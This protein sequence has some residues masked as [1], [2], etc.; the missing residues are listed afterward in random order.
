MKK[1]QLLLLA[2]LLVPALVVAQSFQKETAAIPVSRAGRHLQIPWNGG[3]HSLSVSMPDIDADGDADLLLCGRDE[4]RLQFYRND[5]N[6]AAGE[7]TLAKATLNDL[8]LGRG[9]NR[10]AFHDLDADGDIDLLVGENAG[11]LSFYRNDGTASNPAFSLVTSLFDS[12]DVGFVSAPAFG[13]LD[14]DGGADLLVGSYR[15]GIFYYHRNSSGTHAFT[16]VDTLRDSGGNI[17]KPGFQFYVPA[18]ADIDADGDLDLFASSS[19][20]ALAFYRNTGSA[21]VP[22]FTLENLNFISPP[23][24][25]SFLTPAFVDIDGDLDLDLF[26]GSNH[27][28]VTFYRNDGTPS[29]PSFNLTYQQLNLDFL[30]FGFHAPPVLVDIDGDGDLDLFSGSESGGLH[31]LRN[32]GDQTHPQF[33]WM[34]NRFEAILAGRYTA[35]TWG[36]LDADG[37]FDLLIGPDSQSIYLFTNNGTATSA[38][39]DSIG[40]LHDTT[41]SLVQGFRPELADLDADNDLDLLVLVQTPDQRNAIRLYE[42]I[43]TSQAAIFAM[44][45]DSLRDKDGKLLADYDMFLRLADIDNDGDL[46]LFLGTADGTIVFYQ[47]LGT[48]ANPSFMLVTSFFAGVET[49][50]NARCL[51]FFADIDADNDLDVFVGRFM[52]GLFFYRNITEPSAV[53]DKSEMVAKSFTLEQNYPNPFNPATTI[54]FALPTRSSVTLKLFDML[55]REV[56]TLVDKELQPG[57]HKVVFD[58]RKLP[59]GVYFYLLQAEE[60][61]QTKK[62][63]LLK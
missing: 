45:P 34:T 55:G 52:G 42:N 26:F 27:G 53:N 3:V 29:L 6:G 47:N 61:S 11:Q 22:Q 21:S 13:D 59:S 63:L 40:A 44:Q 8:D 25:M 35:P 5:G 58:A 7:F 30:D 38:Q 31:Y 51:P 15:E 24:F 33:E 36:D 41:G 60:Y 32:T 10:L 18:L 16:F 9:D 12:I 4:G 50:N 23:D 57:A 1:E 46:D 49:G 37:D 2:V 20:P 28:F 19:D 54:R 39:L 62:L 14:N 56:A 17:I 48:A 43:G